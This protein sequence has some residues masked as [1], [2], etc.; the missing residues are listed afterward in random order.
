MSFIQAQDAL[1]AGRLDGQDGMAT[2]FV[3]ARFPA[4]GYRQ[5]LRG[6][7]FGDARVFAVRRPVE[8][9]LGA[10]EDRARHRTRDRF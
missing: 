4:T 5:L 2:S 3:A 1:A 7:A 9:G 10:A 6:G 8:R